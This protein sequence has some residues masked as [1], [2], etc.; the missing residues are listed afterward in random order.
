LWFI[1]C[2]SGVRKLVVAVAAFSLGC[3][4]HGFDHTIGHAEPDD[5]QGIP[6]AAV[7]YDVTGV[8]DPFKTEREH[9]FSSL[10]GYA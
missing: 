5:V 9:I 4:D 2:G 6:K 1:S 7:K 8:P 10:N 3:V